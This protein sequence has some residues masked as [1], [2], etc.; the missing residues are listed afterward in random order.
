MRAKGPRRNNFPFLHSSSRQLRPLLNRENLTVEEL[1]LRIRSIVATESGANPSTSLGSYSCA[2]PYGD[3]MLNST[4]ASLFFRLR[5]N[6][7]ESSG[8]D[9]IC[10]GG[11]SPCSLPTIEASA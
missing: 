10:H 3:A 4:Q 6:T 7:I 2:G 11:G 5:R 9:I 8:V 1:R